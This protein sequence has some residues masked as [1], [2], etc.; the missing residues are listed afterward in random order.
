MRGRSVVEFAGCYAGLRDADFALGFRFRF[1]FRFSVRDIGVRVLARIHGLGDSHPRACR[2]DFVVEVV[3]R[4]N[5]R[6]SNDEG[7]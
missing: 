7:D 2:C 3:A 4:S 1:R 5:R 6:F